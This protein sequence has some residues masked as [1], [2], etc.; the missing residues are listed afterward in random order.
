MNLM[1]PITP[2]TSILPHRILGA[3]QQKPS[4]EAESSISQHN[5]LYE[6][7]GIG[8]ARALSPGAGFP[9]EHSRQRPQLSWPPEFPGSSPSFI[10]SDQ[11]VSFYR[12]SAGSNHGC[13]P[14]KN[15]QE[16]RRLD[17]CHI[18]RCVTGQQDLQVALI[19]SEVLDLCGFPDPHPHHQASTQ[20]SLGALRSPFHGGSEEMTQKA[21]EQGHG[22]DKAHTTPTGQTR[23]KKSLFVRLPV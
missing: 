11:M 21:T 20:L 19:H 16:P 22:P 12:K 6:L 3:K 14:H 15:H 18:T 23:V 9:S 17:Y 7:L 4:P 2:H 8:N 1:G 5:K 10:R 13:C